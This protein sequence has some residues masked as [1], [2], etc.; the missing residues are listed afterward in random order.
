MK[1]KNPAELF[2]AIKKAN[3]SVCR[4]KISAIG[5]NRKGEVIYTSHNK[6]RFVRKAGGV[7]AEEEV[8]KKAGPSLYAIYIIRVNK[9]GGLLPI[10]PC[11]K[12]KELAKKY[13]V[14]INPI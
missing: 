6:P 14:K 1:F 11:P 3:K 5:I 10:D 7:H 9:Q 4:F 13:G 12:C 2:K 8:I